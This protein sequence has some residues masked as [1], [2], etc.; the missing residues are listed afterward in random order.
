MGTL[1]HLVAL[2]NMDIA[3]IVILIAVIWFGYYFVKWV[4]APHPDDVE[5]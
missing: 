2:A 1:L 3:T 5:K 4:F